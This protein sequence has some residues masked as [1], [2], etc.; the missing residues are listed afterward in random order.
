MELTLHDVVTVG[1]ETERNTDS[2]N[3]QLP[4]GNRGLGSSG[5][6]SRPGSIDSSPGADG[7]TDIVGT[8]SEGSSAGSENLDERVGV[9]NLVGV[10][11]GSG[12]DTLHT[13]TLGGTGN[14]RLGSVNIVV[15]TVQETAD[16]HGRNALE[17]G[18]HVAD[19]VDLTGS[20]G[21]VAKEA[22]RPAQGSAALQKL[23][24]VTLLGLSHDFLVAQLGRLGVDE[25]LL[26]VAGAGVLVVLINGTGVG[27]GFVVL[28]ILDDGIVGN[29]GSLASGR[30]G[31]VEQ[32]GTQN[33]HPPLDGVI[34]VEDASLDEG[35][36]KDDGKKADTESG[37]Q[38]H[39]N[40]IPSG[41]LAQ[42][43][44]GRA[45]V[46]NGESTDGGGDQEPEG[47]AVDS[48]GDGVLAHVDDDLDEGE[49][50]GSKATRDDGG[51][52]QTS[53]DSTQTL[54]VVPTPLNLR[55]TNS[56]NTNTS[57]GRD[58][59]V[60]RGDVSRV[61]GAPHDPGGGGSQGNG[62]GHHLNRS[63]ALESCAG[64]DTVLDRLGSTSTDCDCTQELEDRAKNH[65]L[66]VG[67][68]TR[69]NTGCPGV[70]HIVYGS[71]EL[72]SWG[73]NNQFNDCM[74]DLVFAYWHRCCR[75][76]G[77]Q[78]ECRWR[79]H[80]RTRGDTPS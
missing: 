8:V 61:L 12:I 27:R 78:T 19:L 55:S 48:P 65:G 43:Q 58:E 22:H 63:I 67:D 38:S 2:K 70:C 34:P 21:V 33:K 14:T 75:H 28:I 23:L 41:L 3:S 11:L 72:V 17:E 74:D 68:G 79:R 7:V 53:E 77:R 76:Q 37:T 60:G 6:T 59:R 42:A 80:S 20:H 9:L 32:Q 13:L 30:D 49:D 66:S 52:S 73:T 51:H 40:N 35:D 10:L 24:T 64:N 69:G 54:S 25:L 46:D 36:E 18:G 57:N 1:A 56:R 47:R 39:S 15:N 62:E 50:D 26:L 5:L 4:D 16:D 71:S 44:V 29:L 45:L 31:T